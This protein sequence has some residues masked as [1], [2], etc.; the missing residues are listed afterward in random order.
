MRQILS[1]AHKSL[2]VGRRLE[3]LTIFCQGGTAW[4]R[5]EGGRRGAQTG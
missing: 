2:V 5:G 4:G 1:I 3:G